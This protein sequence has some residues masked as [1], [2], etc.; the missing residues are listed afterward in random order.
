MGQPALR[1]FFFSPRLFQQPL[2]H[3]GFLRAAQGAFGGLQ[4]SHLQA[5]DGKQAQAQDRHRHQHFNQRHTLLL[6]AIHGQPPTFPQHIA[7]V[8]DSTSATWIR[9]L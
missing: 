8:A 5:C 1:L 2:P 4:A 7:N 9:N 3:V 6:P